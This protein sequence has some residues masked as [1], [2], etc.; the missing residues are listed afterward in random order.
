MSDLPTSDNPPL[1]EPTQNTQKCLVQLTAQG[2]SYSDYIAESMSPN[3]FR[4]YQADLARFMGR[5]GS[6]P[7][8]PEFLAAYL[9]QHAGSHAVATLLRWKASISKAHRIVGAS[10]PAAS[11]LV[12][13]TL[14]GIKHRHG[15]S[16]QR[17][18]ALLVE[19]LFRV[20]S[21]IGDSTKDA[22]DAALL[23]V[24]FAGGFRRSELVG[25]N[26]EDIEPCRPGLIIHLRRSK[27]DQA[28]AGRKIGIP[29]GRTR[30]CPVAAV[31]E[32]VTK[33]RLV[34]GPIFRSM[35][36]A[37]TASSR[38]LSCEAVSVIIKGRVAA[39]GYDPSEYSGHSLRAGFVTSAA[40]AHVPSWKIRSQTGHAS[41][42]MLE[43][44]IRDAD[45]FRDNA[46]AA[47][48]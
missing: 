22:R 6:I 32:W 3:T 44:Y 27:T 36:R 41:D 25:L 34:D 24:G 9:A 40:Q 35:E 20:L 42:A 38:R 15:T 14:Q 5:G 33:A 46:A 37:G 10:S 30:W 26:L 28:G 16:Q 18:K 4:A 12:R 29:R 45:I 2:R 39:A 23:L 43:R 19:D 48:F 31:E 17:A 1:P 8:S 47:L 7:C 11:E 13:S 21:V